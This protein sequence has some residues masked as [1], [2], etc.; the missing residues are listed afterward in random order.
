MKFSGKWTIGVVIGGILLAALAGC[1]TDDA[2]K[3]SATSG[4]LRGMVYNASR[5]PVLDMNVSLVQAGTAAKTALTDIHGRFL[6]QDVS[7]GPVTLQFGKEGYE[8]LTWSFAF[9]T[10]TQVVYVQSFGLNELLDSA[11][12]SIRKGNWAPAASFLDRVQHVQPD[13]SVVVYLKSEMLA[14]QG[15]PDQAA[16]LLEKLS[17]SGDASFAVELSLADLYQYKLGQ[18]EKAVLHLKKALT[19]QDDADVEKRIATLEKR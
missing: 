9:E 1:A 4:V 16:A 11:A 3:L 17:S 7:Y 18:P 14:R 6:I 12:D 2:S 10:P 8:P 5:M 13:N 15:Y 19:I